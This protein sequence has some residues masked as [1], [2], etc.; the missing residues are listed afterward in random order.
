MKDSKK[1]F[2]N[3]GF[4]GIS[5]CVACCLLPIVAVVFGM[6]ALTVISGYLEW[7]GI[8]TMVLAIIFFAI[9][10]YRKKTATACDIDCECKTENKIANPS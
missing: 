7:V 2:K 3:L 1:L 10:Y 5:L 8:A 4:I 9:Y 6:G